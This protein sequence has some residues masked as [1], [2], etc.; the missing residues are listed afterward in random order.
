MPSTVSILIP[1]AP[2]KHSRLIR[3]PS[4]FGPSCQLIGGSTSAVPVG[5]FVL[6]ASCAWLVAIVAAYTFVLVASGSSG[7][8]NL[9]ASS[10]VR[11]VLLCHAWP[12]GPPDT[13]YWILPQ[14]LITT[15]RDLETRT[16]A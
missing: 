10:A 1:G 7:C 6:F 2:D 11:P 12:D 15:S 16:C 14:D 5:E 4:R 13:R 9:L 3:Y 8:C